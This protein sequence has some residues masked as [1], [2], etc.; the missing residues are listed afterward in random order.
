MYM[1]NERKVGERPKLV[2]LLYG[3]VCTLI[4][5]GCSNMKDSLGMFSSN[6]H[7]RNRHTSGTDSQ[8]EDVLPDTL[9]RHRNASGIGSQDGDVVPDTPEHHRNASG[10][11]SQDGD[12]VPD[13]PE[14]R[15]NASGVD[16]QGDGVVP[17][18][19]TFGSHPAEGFFTGLKFES[20]CEK[21]AD[22]ADKADMAADNAL[23]AYKQAEVYATEAAKYH[24]ETSGLDQSVENWK[25]LFSENIKKINKAYLDISDILNNVRQECRAANDAWCKADNLSE[26]IDALL[27]KLS[28]DYK[29]FNEELDKMDK[30][31][32]SASVR[33]SIKRAERLIKQ[34]DEVSKEAK[35]YVNEAFNSFNKAS[36]YQE[37][38]HIASECTRK[39][40]QDVSSRLEKL[41]LKQ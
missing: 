16:G 34:A 41:N 38:T 8:D 4:L 37:N 36:D 33:N 10:I 24:K 9:K 13:T 17:Q 35:G 6:S 2:V 29:K 3:S 22:Y 27:S 7:K 1:Y 15:R 23:V 21:A 39:C 28:K 30:K 26:E 25:C 14:H 32:A 20:I 5:V 40:L 31:A 18:S 12:V 11:D 19:S